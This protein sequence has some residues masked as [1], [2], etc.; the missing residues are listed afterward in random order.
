MYCACACDEGQRNRN[1]TEKGQR[2]RLIT[3]KRQT[4]RQTAT[5]EQYTRTS[6]SMSGENDDC[7]AAEMKRG[8]Q[9]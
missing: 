8:E 3:Q 2:V 1:M 7:G 5:E 6:S 4:E 9:E